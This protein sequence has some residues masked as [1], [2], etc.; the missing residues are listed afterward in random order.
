MIKDYKTKK[1]DDDK[2]FYWIRLMTNFF[3]RDVIDFLMG[4]KDGANYVVLYLMLL[5]Q[6]ANSEGK[7][8]LEMGEIIMPINIDKIVRDTKYFTKDTVIV[9]LEL[10]K[11]L[12]LIYTNEG[13]ILTL[14]ELPYLIG[15]S[16]GQTI[17]KQ[18]A[19]VEKTL[20]SGNKGGNNGGKIYQQSI[21]YRD[22]SIEYRDIDKDI[23]EKKYIKKRKYGNF[24]N[25]MLTDDEY[26]KLKT[27]NEQ[28][29]YKDLDY[30][31]SIERLDLYIE[32]TGKKYRSHYATILAWHRNNQDNKPKEK[33]KD[34]LLDKILG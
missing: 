2:T 14:A 23:K 3:D 13:G 11:K 25:V 33:V 8:Q 30:K 21:E 29:R 20:E 7:L 22:K 18:I 16:K 24:G 31:E 6:T 5:L 17:R 12:G 9:A 34:K 28:E 10:F 15:T 32:Q 27:I 4:E 1:R 19:N 26:E